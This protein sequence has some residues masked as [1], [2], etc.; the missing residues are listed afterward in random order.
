MWLRCRLCVFPARIGRR[1]GAEGADK[2]PS[3]PQY[4]GC[5]G[6]TAVAWGSILDDEVGLVVK[7]T[8]S[9]WVKVVK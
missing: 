7:N 8:Q 6:G 2:W 3:V 1:Q 5:Q 9:S 4:P